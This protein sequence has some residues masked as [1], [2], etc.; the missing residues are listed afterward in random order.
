MANGFVNCLMFGNH[1]Y[2]K[3]EIP[4]FEEIIT[5]MLG[6]VSGAEEIGAKSVD[7]IVIDTHGNIEVVDNT[8]KVVGPAATSLG[9]GALSIFISLCFRS[10]QQFIQVCLASILCAT[11]VESVNF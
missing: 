2:P 10:I 8:L 11:N 6:G 4:Y 9:T 7:L 1:K 5:L 3:L